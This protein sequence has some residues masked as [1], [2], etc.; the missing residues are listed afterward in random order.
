MTNRKLELWLGAVGKRQ[1]A[2]R[3]CLPDELMPADIARI[4]LWLA[5]SDSRMCTAQNSGVDAGWV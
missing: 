1:I 4:V 5:A 2:E 3:Q